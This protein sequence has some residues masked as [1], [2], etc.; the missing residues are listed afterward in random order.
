M[1]R[2]NPPEQ[3]AFFGLAKLFRHNAR[4]PEPTGHVELLYF[5][6]I[7]G[8]AFRWWKS[9]NRLGFA[10]LPALAPMSGADLPKIG[11]DQVA[12]QH[13]LSFGVTFLYQGGD[14]GDRADMSAVGRELV[15]S[16]ID[17]ILALS[18][19]HPDTPLCQMTYRERP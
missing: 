18:A 19:A 8:N 11:A 6:F 13:L 3:I 10:G 7:D 17:V 12:I 2:R 1:S 5:L 15:S 16:P 14:Y 9:G 4:L